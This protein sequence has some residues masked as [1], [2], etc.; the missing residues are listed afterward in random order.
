VCVTGECKE[1]IMLCR[2]ARSEANM[3]YERLNF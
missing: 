3:N 2:G 1:K